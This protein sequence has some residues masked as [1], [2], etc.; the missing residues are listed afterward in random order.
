MPDAGMVGH[1]VLG[2]VAWRSYGVTAAAREVGF[3]GIQLRVCVFSSVVSSS[4]EFKSGR[5][6]GRW[7]RRERG[8][9]RVPHALAYG[10]RL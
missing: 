8:G 1:A 5:R 4:I 3:P 7:R 9:W 2:S 10:L 6:V